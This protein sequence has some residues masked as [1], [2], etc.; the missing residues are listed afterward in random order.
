MWLLLARGNSVLSRLILL[1]YFRYLT[2]GCYWP[3][4]TPSSPGWF[5]Y[6]IFVTWPVAATGWRQLRPRPVDFVILFIFVTR[7][8]AVTGWR[9]LR[10]RPVEFIHP[11]WIITWLLLLIA[12][13]IVCGLLLFHIDMIL[14]FCIGQLCFTWIWYCGFAWT[15]PLFGWTNPMLLELLWKKLD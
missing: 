9:H 3:E 1:F 14:W 4:A 7:P 8:V 13:T 6:F 5:C 11:C 15:N 10:H 12:W 2:C